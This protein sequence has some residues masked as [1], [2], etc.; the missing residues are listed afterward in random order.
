MAWFYTHC[1]VALLILIA[2]TRGTLE[3]AVKK[4]EQKLGM[5]VYYASSDSLDIDINDPYPVGD[6]PE[7]DTFNS[8]RENNESGT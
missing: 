8:Q 5:P 2:D 6:T 7:Q 1:V 4:I 3:P